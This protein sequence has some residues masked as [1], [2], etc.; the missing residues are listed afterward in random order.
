MKIMCI[1]TQCDSIFFLYVFVFVVCV[2]AV[3]MLCV[4]CLDRLE[5]VRL[6]SGRHENDKQAESHSLFLHRVRRQLTH[7]A[8]EAQGSQ[9]F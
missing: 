6:P 4:T 9:D 7:D 3:C 2:C 1:N 5:V 8:E